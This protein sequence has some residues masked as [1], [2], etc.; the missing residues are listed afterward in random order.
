M[1]TPRYIE[2]KNSSN[3]MGLA[4]DH[5]GGTAYVEFIGGRRYAFSMA[6]AIFD[7]LRTA[8]SV[9]TFFARNVK[10][11]YPSPWNGQ[12]CS[13]SPCQEDATLQGAVAGGVFWVCE[14]CSKLPPFVGIEFIPIPPFTKKEKKK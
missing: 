1:T 2:V 7:N 3:V 9:G 10:G 6:H 13:S 5:V 14:K 11:K 4:Y 12:R 8:K